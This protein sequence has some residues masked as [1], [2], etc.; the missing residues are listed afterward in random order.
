M[1]ATIDL[2]VSTHKSLS[3]LVRVQATIVVGLPPKRVWSA[4][5]SLLLYNTPAI[6][7][8]GKYFI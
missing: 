1:G 2:Y 4:N 6:W 8:T 7:V 3:R 5:A